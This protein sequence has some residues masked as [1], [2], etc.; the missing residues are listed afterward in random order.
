M[1]FP[2]HHSVLWD[3][4]SRLSNTKLTSV[5]LF[6]YSYP[7][8][9][10]Q[11]MSVTTLWYY[12]GYPTDL[13]QLMSVTT[14]W[15]YIIAATQQT[16]DNLCQWLLCEVILKWL[17]NRPLTTY[18]NDYPVRLYYSGYPTDLWQL[19]SVTTLWGY[20]IVA[21]QQTSDN[22]CQWLTCEVSIYSCNLLCWHR[23]RWNSI[24]SNLNCHSW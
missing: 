13:W 1:K 19:M 11:L 9:L 18:V 10:W 23:M 8:D 2:S 16:S 7:T 20:I 4:S 6:Q 21:T 5:K 15:A 24:I 12:S 14:L 17:P 22:L 3:Y